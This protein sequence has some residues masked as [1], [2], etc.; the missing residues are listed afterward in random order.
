MRNAYKRFGALLTVLRRPMRGW[1]WYTIRSREVQS[2]RYVRLA[3]L[4][5]TTDC[6]KALAE[7]LC[8]KDRSWFQSRV[9]CLVSLLQVVVSSVR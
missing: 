1:F 2:K 4:M 5:V 3:T 9:A 8:G 6:S 7:C